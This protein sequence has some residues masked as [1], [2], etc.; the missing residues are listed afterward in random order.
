LVWGGVQQQG[1]ANPPEQE[2]AL[3]LQFKNLSENL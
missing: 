3:P 2:V 1:I